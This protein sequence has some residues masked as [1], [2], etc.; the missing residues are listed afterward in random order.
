MIVILAAFFASLRFAR[1]PC[2]E[3]VKKFIRFWQ[4]GR[5]YQDGWRGKQGYLIV[6]ASEV[7]KKAYRPHTVHYVTGFC[8]FFGGASRSYSDL[9]Q[10]LSYLLVVSSFSGHLI[11]AVTVPKMQFLSGSIK[12]QT[13]QNRAR[14]QEP[15]GD[16]E[17]VVPLAK[18][19]Q[20]LWFT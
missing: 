3:V 20:V 7:F 18:V 17:A 6:A 4:S 9:S 13:A 14:N 12:I 2:S 11:M 8:I 19:Q 10:S 16:L 5:L 1:H 15:Q